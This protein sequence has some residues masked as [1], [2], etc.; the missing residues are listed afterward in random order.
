M[1]LVCLSFSGSFT[2]RAAAVTADTH[3]PPTRHN[4]TKTKPTH[5]VFLLYLN[6]GA[7]VGPQNGT[8]ARGVVKFQRMAA[9]VLFVGS[10]CSLLFVSVV[11]R[12]AARLHARERRLGLGACP[13]R[14]SSH[15]AA[16]SSYDETFPP[17]P[18]TA[19]SSGSS[20]GGGGGK[21]RYDSFASAAS[22]ASASA[23][24]LLGGGGHEQ[25]QGE[26]Q[27]AASSASYEPLSA[28]MPPG[29][30]LQHYESVLLPAVTRWSDWFRVPD[31][32]W[33]VGMFGVCGCGW[34]M[35][36][37]FWWGHSCPLSSSLSHHFVCTS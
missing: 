22:S 21:G 32:Y 28:L 24:S 2:T 5:S 3:A 23:G 37:G 35:N 4:T 10:L 9:A 15:P 14:P 33:W 36:V 26:Q 34:L 7:D 11:A 31:F 16:S 29:G 12:H 1:V 18:P 19:T 13:P 8:G 25:Q 20:S 6:G 17:P 27:R 30:S